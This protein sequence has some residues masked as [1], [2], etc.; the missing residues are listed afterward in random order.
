MPTKRSI[1]HFAA[2]FSLKGIDGTQAPGDY[3]VDQDEEQI[4]GV[5][6][7]AYR[8]VGTFIHLPAI[9]SKSRTS[10]MVAV[11]PLEL[12][13]ALELDHQRAAADAGSGPA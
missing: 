3:E 6:W 13:A 1:V 9:G 10:M 2:P 4:E 11:D 7:L 12:D 8:R 5:S